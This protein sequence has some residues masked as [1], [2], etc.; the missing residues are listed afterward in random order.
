MDDSHPFYL[1]GGALKFESAFLYSPMRYYAFCDMIHDES[2]LVYRSSRTAVA[3]IA[4]FLNQ[5]FEID[6][7]SK[8]RSRQIDATCLSFGA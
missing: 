2:R 3:E 6:R 4:S 7:I 8:A 5:S 1:M